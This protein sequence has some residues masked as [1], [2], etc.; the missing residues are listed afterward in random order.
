MNTQEN[1]KNE[2]SNLQTHAVTD[3]PVTD[4]EADR[5]TGGSTFDTQGRVLVGTDGGLW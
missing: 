2:E 3:L 5:A 4:E 1:I